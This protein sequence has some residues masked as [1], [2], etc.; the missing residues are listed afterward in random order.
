MQRQVLS[1]GATDDVMS[2]ILPRRESTVTLICYD[3]SM[4]HM[5][6]CNVG[7]SKTVFCTVAVRWMHATV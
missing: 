5:S 6:I 1:L 2:C 4:L 3:N 7:G